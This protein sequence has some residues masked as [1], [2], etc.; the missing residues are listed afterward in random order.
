M[1]ENVQYIDRPEWTMVDEASSKSYMSM[2]R[3]EEINAMAGELDIRILT[4]PK[5]DGSCL[6]ISTD[7]IR[8]GV[9]IPHALTHCAE[10]TSF[11]EMAKIVLGDSYVQ[12]V[13]KNILRVHNRRH[14]R[15]RN[16]IKGEDNQM[17]LAGMSKGAWWDILEKTSKYNLSILRNSQKK[18]IPLGE[19]MAQI[20]E[21][22][23]NE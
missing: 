23:D 5:F 14:P 20:N 19:V 3:M 15:K 10:D 1:F 22:R 18:F 17:G 11:G 9:L 12:F 7:L 21:S 8:A 2:E 13:I 4:E 16:Y 6:V